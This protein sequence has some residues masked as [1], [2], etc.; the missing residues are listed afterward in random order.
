MGHSELI[1]MGE[2]CGRAGSPISRAPS[3]VRSEPAQPRRGVSGAE[4][5]AARYAFQRFQ[6][7]WRAHYPVIVK[8]RERDLPELLSF[9]G[10]PT[11]LW[12]QLRMT[13]LTE[14]VFAEARRHTR[15]M[16]R[17]CPSRPTQHRPD[18]R[19][20]V[21]GAGVGVPNLPEKRLHLK[22]SLPSA[23]LREGRL[24]YAA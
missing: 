3:G 7:Q 6:K 15:P 22:A 17:I 9:F 16:R 13:N 4:R 1:K 24:L 12:R 18:L 23:V 20:P 14:R 2:C 11:H 19:S 8:Q 5:S 21:R 10:F